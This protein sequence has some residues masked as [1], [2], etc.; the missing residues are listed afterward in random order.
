MTP[1][2]ATSQASP[3]RVSS[4]TQLTSH[5]APSSAEKACSQ[6]QVLP[7]MGDQTNRTR[8]GRPPN[9]SR[10]TNVPTPSAKPPTTG[11]SRTPGLRPSSHQIDQVLV[12][13]SNDRSE[14]ARYVPPGSSS[15]LSSTL[16]APA[17]SGH[18]VDV[19]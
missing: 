15:T 13:G 12:A 14:S 10:P 19:P 2:A 8:I 5:D 11:G 16:P 1:V 9:V 17:R 6:R 18:A 4:M 3:M 7:S